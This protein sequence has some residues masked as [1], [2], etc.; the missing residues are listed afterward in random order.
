MHADVSIQLRAPPCSLTDFLRGVWS[1][2]DLP[3]QLCLAVVGCISLQSV[4]SSSASLITVGISPLS[5]PKVKGKV[6]FIVI[7]QYRNAL[8]NAIVAAFQ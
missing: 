6:R 1:W 2:T 5:F 3:G 8:R 4:A 7:T